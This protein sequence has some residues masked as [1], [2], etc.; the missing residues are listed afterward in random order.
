MSNPAKRAV[1]G[2]DAPVFHFDGATPVPQLDGD[3]GFLMGME[4]Q[5]FATT[6]ALTR[7]RTVP[8]QVRHDLSG[9]LRRQHP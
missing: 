9:A 4:W 1:A 3:S 7:T 8:S 6:R 5:G 2:A